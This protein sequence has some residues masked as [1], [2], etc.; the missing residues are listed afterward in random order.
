M[1]VGLTTLVIVKARQ[2]SVAMTV[3]QCVVGDQTVVC[4]VGGYK[5]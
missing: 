3:T 5:L 4:V 2:H 1:S